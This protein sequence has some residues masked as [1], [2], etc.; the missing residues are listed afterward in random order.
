MNVDTKPPRFI[1]GGFLLCGFFPVILPCNAQP[2][3]AMHPSTMQP[4]AMQSSEFAAYHLPALERDEA[5]H[6]LIVAVLGRLAG[7]NP[8]DL[9][10]WSLGEPGQC[11]IKAPG[12]PIVLGDLNVAQCHAFAEATRSLD[13]PA[14]VG[15]DETPR[16]F[17]ERARELGVTF[18]E[19]IPQQIQVLRDKPVYP[20]V[21]GHARQLAAADTPLF[22]DWMVAFVREAIPQDPVPTPEQLAQSAASG[23]FQFWIV[24]GEPVSV[25]GIMRRTLHA[26]AIAGA[27]T[28]PGLRGRGYAEVGGR[29]HLCRRPGHR[30]SLRRFA[31]PLY[32]SL[33]RQDRFHAT[34][35]V[36]VLPKG[37]CAGFRAGLRTVRQRL[38]CAL[39]ET[40]L[41][42]A[43]AP[44]PKFVIRL[45]ML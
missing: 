27:Y 29:R 5:R 30:L 14:V 28:P 25:A 22:S 15:A 19:S 35:R 3:S 13:Y 33:L 18:L 9:Q 8:P 4:R 43:T 10:W 42:A 32:P 17:V 23:R 24:D 16:W 36:L 44:F 2:E 45:S 6:N 37:L 34:V 26:A 38:S 12:Y 21:P 7:E 39:T 31:Q 1:R 40:T 41:R 20:G 11:A